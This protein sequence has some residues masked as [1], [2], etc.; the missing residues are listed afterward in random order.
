MIL[1][2]IRLKPKGKFMRWFFGNDKCEQKDCISS[3][4]DYDVLILKKPVSYLNKRILETRCRNCNK[5]TKVT[6]YANLHRR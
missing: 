6:K 4:C 2:I 3:R 5:I 1:E